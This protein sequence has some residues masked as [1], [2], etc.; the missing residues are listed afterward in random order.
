MATREPFFEPLPV[1]DDEPEGARVVGNVPWVPPLNV[2][3]VLVPLGVELAATDDV[4][5]GLTHV[6]VYDRGAE[7]HL[8]G[9]LHPEALSRVEGP[10]GLR[11][12]PRV[13]LLLADGTKVGAAADELLPPGSAVAG[14]TTLSLTAGGSAELRLT[15]AWWVRPVPTEPFELVVSWPDVGVP[16][17][18]ITLDGAAMEAASRGARELWPLPDLEGDFGWFADAPGDDAAY[19]PH[20]NASPAGDVD[21]GR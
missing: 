7:L 17:T 14:G 10:Y 2:V 5:L 3:P 15:Q 6:L 20:P 9:W 16:E 8:Q 1:P 13:G 19:R 18:F 21:M 4:V 12:E 11:S